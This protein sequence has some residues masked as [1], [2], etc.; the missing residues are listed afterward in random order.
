[1]ASLASPRAGRHR[2][3]D[4]ERQPVARDRATVPP[5]EEQRSEPE[6]DRGGGVQESKDGVEVRRGALTGWSRCRWAGRMVG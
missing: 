3:L 4:V 6:D 2:R 5:E 1:M